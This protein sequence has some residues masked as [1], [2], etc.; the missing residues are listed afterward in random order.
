M[1]QMILI[2]SLM[3]VD[4]RGDDYVYTPDE[5]YTYTPD[6][7]YTDESESVENNP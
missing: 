4:L 1:M 5:D 6:E 3:L 7:G 2:N